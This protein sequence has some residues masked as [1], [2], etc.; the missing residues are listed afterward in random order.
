MMEFFMGVFIAS[1]FWAA[2]WSAASMSE[3]W[4]SK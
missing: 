1:I 2:I 4:G 3:W